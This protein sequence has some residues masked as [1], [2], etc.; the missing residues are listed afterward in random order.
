L[1]VGIEETISL[2]SS[3]STVSNINCSDSGWEV[4][5]NSDCERW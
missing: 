4:G 1:L 3:Q 2:I 5:L